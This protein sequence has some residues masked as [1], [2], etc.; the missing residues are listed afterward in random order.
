MNADDLEILNKKYDKDFN[1]ALNI[2]E[3]D[4]SHEDLINFL[5]NGTVAEK[6][7]AVLKLD[8]L[9]SKSEAEIF[10]NNLTGCDGKIREAVSFRL[11]DFMVENP[12]YFVDYAEIFLDAVVDINGNICRNTIF[13]LRY[14]RNF[15]QFCEKFCAELLRRSAELAQK[16]KDFD[17]QEGKYKIN[18]EIFKLYW[19]LET[20]CEFVDYV[21]KS[22][23]LE[24]LNDTGQIIDYTIREKT[25]KIL[26]KLDGNEFDML[27][28]KLQN[29]ENYYV[30][31]ILT[32]PSSKP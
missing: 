9:K 6:Q 29:D 31:R 12:E 10:M 11:K 2:Y 21:D 24:I 28:T 32:T 15:P 4:Y 17:I 30:R 25:A 23:L 14:L 13:A 16:A 22:E 26:T 5:K 18:K 19:Y 8:N 7:T 3:N 20:I 1:Q 27:K